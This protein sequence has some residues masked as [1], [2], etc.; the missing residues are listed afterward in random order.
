MLEI[1]IP[2]QEAF[3][4]STNSFIKLKGMKLSM[5]HSLVSIY[6]WESKWHKPFLHSTK[7]NAEVLDYIRCMTITQNVP[8]DVYYRIPQSEINKIQA[9]IEDPMTATTF[10]YLEDRKRKREIVTAE[11]IYYWMVA[12]NVPFE[13]Q[14]WHLNKLLTLL[15]VISEKN[16][17]PKKMSKSQIAKQ[18]AAL[19]AARKAKLHTRG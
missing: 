11:I 1:T 8:D 4:E 15:Q 7:T 12:A 14:K 6:K 19:N 17:P 3:D 13:C 2:E 5:E 16:K 9:Y 18:Y 10:H